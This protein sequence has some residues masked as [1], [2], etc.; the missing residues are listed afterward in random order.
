MPLLL[1]SIFVIMRI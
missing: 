1:F